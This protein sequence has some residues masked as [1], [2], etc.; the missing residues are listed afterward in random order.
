MPR[1]PVKKSG[2][3]QKPRSK[4]V[5]KRTSPNTK[6][7]KVKKT[8]KDKR[9]PPQRKEKKAW[10]PP[11]PKYG[12]SKL[13]EKFAKEFLEPLGIKYVYQYEART[14]GRFFDFYIPDENLLIEVD[15]D[16][17]HSYGLVYEQM[18]PMQKHN[19]RVDEEKNHWAA[20]NCIPL[21]RIWEHDINKRPEIVKEVLS[22][23]IKEARETK[24]RKEKM[25]QRH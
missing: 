6:S 23:Y 5:K 22:Q 14:I 19:K 11:H 21:L 2:P 16:F 9:L 8:E 24:E 3:F 13:E 20:I 12:T 10:K 1:Q 15:G 25:K 7:V 17:Y 18:S 4:T